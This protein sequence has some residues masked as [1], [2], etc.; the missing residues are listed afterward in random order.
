MAVDYTV[1]CWKSFIDFAVDEAL[2]IPLL[3]LR[4]N[5]SAVGDMVLDEI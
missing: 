3:R 4:I 5:G 1:D 2:L